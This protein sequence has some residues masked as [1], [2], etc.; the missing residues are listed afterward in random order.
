MGR[1]PDETIQAIRDRVD[2][3]EL[4]GRFVALKPAGRN[5]KGLCPFHDEKTPSFNVNAD[6]QIFHCFGCG[7]GGNAFTFLMRH[8]NLTFPEAARE[9]GRTV[10]V[11]VREDGGPEAGLSE[12]LGQ[13]NDAA[14]AFFREELASPRGAAARRY[15]AERGL[16]A[17]TLDAFGIGFAPERWDGLVEGLRRAR[18]PADLAARA[19]LLAERESGGHYDRLRGRVTFPIRDAR[20]R[21]LGFGG[22][23][24]GRDQEP[25]YL[26]SPETPLYRK[27]E[28]L[29]GFPGALEPMRRAGRAVVVEGYFD[30][31]ALHRAGLG[32]TV[33]TCGTALTEDHARG[34]RRRTREVVLL[35][36]GDE[37]GRRAVRGALEVLLPAGLRVRTAVLPDGHD[38]DTWLAQEGPEALVR[39]VDEARPALEVAIARA[40]EGGLATPWERADAVHDVAPLVARVADAVE[41]GEYARLLAMRTGVREADVDA[42]VA[43]VRRGASAEEAAPPEPR[44]RGPEDRWLRNLALAVLDHPHLA[45]RVPVDELAAMFP[46]MAAC[47]L[48]REMAAALRRAGELEARL[49]GEIQ[50]LYTELVATEREP[51]DE[52]AALRAIDETLENLRR[53]HHRRQRSEATRLHAGRDEPDDEALLRLKNEQLRERRELWKIPPGTLRH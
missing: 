2:L 18:I 48:L 40:C 21:V 15:L 3:V 42:A 46:G 36:D 28:V 10:G 45:E 37:A 7:T 50:R 53:R 6:R 39:L 14:Q 30:V 1:I 35:F 12:R 4:V 17:Q 9:L 23:A 19:G 11:E 41:R 22:R 26:N 33:A 51:L 25:K 27:R 8:E 24:L 20:G 29:F 43:A 47:G 44:R 52:E 34:L 16:D 32:E 38:P 13:A 5:H 31:V 49:E